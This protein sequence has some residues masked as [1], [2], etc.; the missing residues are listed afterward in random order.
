M[1]I[2]KAVITVTMSN[3]GP[4]AYKPEVYDSNIIIERTLVKSGASCYKFR[5]ERNGKTLASKRDELTQICEWFNVTVDS[6][7]TVLTQDQARSFLQNADNNTM[8][9]VSSFVI[10]RNKG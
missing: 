7:L 4:E 6:P 5:A 3:E 2:S 9:K 10:P 8:Y 1:P